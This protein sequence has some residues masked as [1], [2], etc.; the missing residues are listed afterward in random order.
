MEAEP[1]PLDQLG[2]PSGTKVLTTISNN[3]E[4]RLTNEMCLA[5][6]EILQSC[7]DACYAPM[8]RVDDE[9][10]LRRFFRQHKVEDR[11]FF[12]GSVSKPSQYARSMHIYLN[13]FPFG[14][15]LGMLDAMAAGCPV[16]SMYDMKGPP[17]ARYGGDY[18]G[19]E[20]VSRQE[21]EKTMSI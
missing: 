19:L 2:L 21:N 18:F 12:L 8:G 5:I 20:R 17:Q 15:C 9:G 11:I 13:E 14:S 7:P 6:A 10:K 4:N 16:V 1:Y 3:L